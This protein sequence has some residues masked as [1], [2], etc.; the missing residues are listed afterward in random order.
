MRERLAQGHLSNLKPASNWDLPTLAGAGAPDAPGLKVG[1]GCVGR[2]VCS[3]SSIAGRSAI[4]SLFP[5]DAL[6]PRSGR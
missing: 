4:S 2:R 5:D 6:P 1:L 3:I